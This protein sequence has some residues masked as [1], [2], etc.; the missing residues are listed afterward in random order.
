M[1][2]TEI[3]LNRNTR[4]GSRR[5]AYGTLTLDKTL[6]ITGVSVF[7]GEKGEYVRLPQYKKG[8]G[9]YADIVFPTTAGLRKSINKRVLS[10]YEKLAA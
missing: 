10:A 1:K 7:R 2:I 4:E 6:V 8:D 3:K 5:L 9:K